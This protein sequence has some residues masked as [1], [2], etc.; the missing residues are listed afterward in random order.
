MAI[1]SFTFMLVEVPAP[2]CSSVDGHLVAVQ[3][4]GELAAGALDGVGLG[5]VVGPDAEVAVG[6]GGGELDRAVGT[7]EL[8]VHRSPGE[9]EVGPCAHGVHPEQGVGRH[10]DLAEQVGLDALPVARWVGL[11]ALPVLGVGLDA[12]PV[13]HAPICR[14]SPLIHYVVIAQAGVASPRA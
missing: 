5:R 7:D 4:V 12:L 2:P 11:G 1:T 6:Q 10:R 8:A 9:A 3:A 13:A 14:V